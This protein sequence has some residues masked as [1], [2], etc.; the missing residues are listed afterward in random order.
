MSREVSAFLSESKSK[1]V[2][3]AV[4]HNR[5]RPHNLTALELLV[6]HATQ[7]KTCLYL[8]TSDFRSRN[9]GAMYPKILLQRYSSDLTSSGT[10]KKISE[11]Y[12]VRI[13]DV[14]ISHQHREISHAED[15]DLVLSQ[16]RITTSESH[17]RSL[18][19]RGAE[20]GYAI[21]SS[22][23]ERHKKSSALN[24]KKLMIQEALI[25]M[26]TFDLVEDLCTTHSIDRLIV[27]NG[28]FSPERAS[29]SAGLAHSVDVQI[30]ESVIGAK[31]MTSRLGMHSI[32]GYADDATSAW[33]N[34]TSGHKRGIGEIWFEQRRNNFGSIDP[35]FK[36]SRLASIFSRPVGALERQYA[37]TKVLKLNTQNK[38]IAS[39][40]NT[41]D[42]E[43]YS[44]SPEWE[45][46]NETQFSRFYWASQE[47]L[48]SGFFVVLRLHPNMRD[49]P[50]SSLVQWRRLKELGVQIVEYDDV[51]NSYSL[52]EC[53]D[54]VVT[55]GSTTGLEASAMKKP[56][57]LIGN[58][59]YEGLNCVLP[60]H[61][62]ETFRRL[63]T[64]KEDETLLDQLY[65]NSLIAGFYEASK[66]HQRK[67]LI[68]EV[69]AIFDDRIKPSVLV[70]IAGIL[71]RRWI[72]VTEKTR[73]FIST[74]NT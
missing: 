34:D 19:Y 55:A 43:F 24:S 62:V 45:G 47:L 7:G 46:S 73:V 70:Q 8:N 65:E 40:F 71:M 4:D 41:S 66:W 69:D 23:Y 20:L 56:S 39:L 22:I 25:F 18:K 3:L 2:V 28:R 38:P 30:H 9:Y 12:N 57:I 33:Q 49:E 48:A 1:E 31:F 26:D 36:K 72:L 53:S 61:D 5:W 74:L 64:F 52:I 68:P 67:W 6:G 21:V 13:L 14:G 59:Y 42:R 58:A 17:I 60:C 50:K 29:W 35:W 63:L 10:I 44:I 27:F 37:L 15:R 16:I 32:S 51:L 54:I 11:H